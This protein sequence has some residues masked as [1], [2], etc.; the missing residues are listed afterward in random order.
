MEQLS[1]FDEEREQR[2]DKQTDVLSVVN[3]KF[4]SSEKKNWQ[5]L[6]DGFDEIYT[7]TFSSGID[8]ISKVMDKYSY[9][10]VIFGCE[11]VVDDNVAA[12]MAVQ[13]ALIERI[14]KR[15]S[16]KALA[17]MVENNQLKLFVSRDVKSHEKI[18]CLKAND[19]RVRVITGSANMSASAFCGFQRENICVFDDVEAYEW[20]KGRFDEF[21]EI[22]A[23]N[24]NIKTLTATIEDPDYLRDEV[25]EIPISKTVQ[26]KKMVFLEPSDDTED[27]ELV[28]SVKGLEADLKPMLPKL[29]KEGSKILLTSEHVRS[30]QARNK[31]ARE[32]IKAKQKKLPK[33]HLDYETKTLSFNGKECNLH[34]DKEKITNDVK[35]LFNFMD[36]YNLFFG[37][38]ADAQRDYFAFMNW[39]FAS[40][41]MAY[42]RDVANST[43]YEV[44]AFPVNGII[45]GDSN[46]GKSTFLKLLSKMMCDKKMPRNSSADYT[47]TTMED[48]KRGIEG[49]PIVV[50]DLDKTQFNNHSSKIIK[51][52]DWGVREHFINYP[53]IAITTNKVPSLEPA[54]SK[55]CIGCRISIKISKEDAAK[56]G[57]RLNESMNKVSN[58]FYCEYVRRMF[59]KVEEMADCMKGNDQEYFPDIFKAS[60]E[61]ICEIIKELDIEVPEYV[62]EL[63]YG[64]YF[65][66]KVVGKNAI[67]KLVNAW[68]T[69]PQQFKIDRKANKITYV[70]PENF[71]MYELKYINEEL[72]PKLNSKVASRTLTMDLDVAEEFFGI[73]FKKKLFSR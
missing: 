32:E 59:V 54:I 8:F 21:K 7:I 46:G 26:D 11:N 15:K 70:V 28:A 4:I 19:G 42:L 33:L 27:Y 20:Y 29:K 10:E 51:D 43:N 66:E 30:L 62:R 45:Y 49:H 50:D 68:K 73:R 18:F 17:E 72:P 37:D 41:F 38:I 48:L 3:T 60:S 6:F 64:D 9:G 22:C 39:F 40:P 71:N 34:P 12:I 1:F 25:E 58:S 52:D 63:S 31:P 61:T 5:N 56:N 23:D 69:E 57:K 13:T 47:G 55:R 35:Y 2:L 24:V 67:N 16:A 36:G 65:G 14:T 44:M 53:A